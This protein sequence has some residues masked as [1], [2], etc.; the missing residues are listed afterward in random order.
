M[1]DTAELRSCQLVRAS[2]DYVFSGLEV[3]AALSFILCVV[4]EFLAATAGLGYFLRAA[5]YNIDAA[6]MFAAV[7]VLALL[8]SLLAMAVRLAHHRVVFWKYHK[9]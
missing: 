1:Q 2:L 6:S 4:G 3:C 9:N 5:S 7:V 8:A